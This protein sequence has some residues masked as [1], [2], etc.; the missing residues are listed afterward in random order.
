MKFL[1]YDGPFA[2]GVQLLWRYF[3]LNACFILCSLPIITIGAS[4]SALYAVMLPSPQDA[5]YIKKYFRAFCSNFSQATII[6]LIIAI[7][8]SLLLFVLY[9]TLVVSFPGYRAFRLLSF[10][11][12]IFLMALVSYVFPLQA[13]YDNPPKTTIRNAFILCIG[14]FL[15]GVL[16][17]LVS[18]IPI[19]TFMISIDTFIKLIA[20]W[21]FLGFSLTSRINSSI[22]MYVFS[23]L[24]PPQNDD[25]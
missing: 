15:P 8:L 4:T 19:L 23:R 10:V 25:E 5:G 16:M 14:A 3:I 11:L 13:R 18:L 21:P 12:L 2:Q 17:S 22:C 1:S 6:W 20:F 24:D 9:L 7:P